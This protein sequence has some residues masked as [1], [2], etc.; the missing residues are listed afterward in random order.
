MNRD[1]DFFVFRVVV[2]LPFDFSADSVKISIS[3]GS[4]L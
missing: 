3:I 4:T 2:K 1:V